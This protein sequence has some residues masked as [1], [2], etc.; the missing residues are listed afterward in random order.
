MKERIAGFFLALIFV[1]WLYFPI[2]GRS[3]QEYLLRQCIT[4]QIK[5]YERLCDYVR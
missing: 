2:A 5:E 1:C 3:L 4:Y